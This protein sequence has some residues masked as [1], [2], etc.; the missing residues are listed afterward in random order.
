MDECWSY[1]GNKNNRRWTWYAIN[2]KSG[3]IVTW[4]N[5]KRDNTTCA[6]LLRK[7]E[8]FPIRETEFPTWEIEF[9]TWEIEFH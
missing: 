2:L 9:P 3:L 6:E 7:M 5:G 1:V 8:R 4:Q